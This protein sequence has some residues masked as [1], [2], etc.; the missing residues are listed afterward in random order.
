MQ[1]SGGEGRGVNQASTR[2]GTTGP[3]V[4]APSDRILKPHSLPSMLKQGIETLY[5]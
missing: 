5:I 3:S 4:I 2:Y 1:G